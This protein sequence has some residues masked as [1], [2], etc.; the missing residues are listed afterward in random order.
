[1]SGWYGGY[2]G[3]PAWMERHAT[4]DEPL[5]VMCPACAGDGTL[6][7]DEIDGIAGMPVTTCDECGGAGLVYE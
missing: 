5:G 2:D 6:P 7:C 3:F 1:M 4:R